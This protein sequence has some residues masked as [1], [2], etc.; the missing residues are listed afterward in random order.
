MGELYNSFRNG[1]KTSLE[2]EAAIADRETGQGPRE[3]N[4]DQRLL[5]FILFPLGA[6][7]C[8]SLSG[9]MGATV[10]FLS[11]EYR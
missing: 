3:G 11:T 1:G 6:S 8:L 2:Y 5:L 7:H 4:S 10:G 9:S